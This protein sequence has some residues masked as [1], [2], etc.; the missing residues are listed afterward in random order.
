MAAILRSR[1]VIQLKGEDVPFG[2]RALEA[3]IVV[4][5]V[6]AVSTPSVTARPSMSTL[7]GAD[8][9]GSERASF[10]SRISLSDPLVSMNTPRS[11]E[12]RPQ[13]PSP[14]PSPYQMM[15]PSPKEIG[16][17]AGS[18]SS[19]SSLQSTNTSA[20]STPDYPP[21]HRPSLSDLKLILDGGISST[22][23]SPTSL[24]PSAT[25]GE[26][27]PVLPQ[28][29]ATMY[30]YPPKIGSELVIQAFYA[31]KVTVNPTR[32]ASST[33]PTRYTTAPTSSSEGTPEGSSH[34]DSSDDYELPGPPSRS[35]LPHSPHSAPLAGK[36][37]YTFARGSED[38]SLLQSHRLSHAA[39]VGQLMPRRQ[40]IISEIAIGPTGNLQVHP[41]PENVLS[42]DIAIP[43]PAAKPKQLRVPNPSL[44]PRSASDS[45]ARPVPHSRFIEDFTLQ[46]PMPSLSPP[47]PI[48]ILPIEKKLKL[49]LGQP[50]V[51]EVQAALKSGRRKL[52][53]K[54]RTGPSIILLD[55]CYD[56][57]YDLEAQR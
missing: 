27:L 33:P 48:P 20:L 30:P 42:W 57:E 34:S 46:S 44:G 56:K 22:E 49:P 8:I 5:G 38:L 53:K 19:N 11:Q 12:K 18:E 4:E 21:E 10:D 26:I 37:S 3:G 9:K 55:G 25:I 50:Q 45:L 32:S 54:N 16:A 15:P 40:R 2:I 28:D 7:A 51:R 52:Q 13:Y 6:Y 47:E 23:K 39:E 1:D 24:S 36:R 35:K 17:R 41:V 31:P 29:T 14:Q 43:P